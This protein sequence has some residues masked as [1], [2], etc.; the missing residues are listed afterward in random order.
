MS[1]SNVKSP[2]VPRMGSI[3]EII[4]SPVFIIFKNIINCELE[5]CDTQIASFVRGDD[6]L[7][8]NYYK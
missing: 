1:T 4:D 8:V 6:G 2:I 5:Q 3:N 7:G